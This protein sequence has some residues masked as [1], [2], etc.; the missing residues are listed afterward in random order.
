VLG[1][2]LIFTILVIWFWRRRLLSITVVGAYTAMFLLM[3]YVG[4]VLSYLSLNPLLIGFS[5]SPADGW[6]AI[7]ILHVGIF[8]L[9]LGVFYVDHFLCSG[10]LPGLDELFSSS[11]LRVGM[12]VD[13]LLL[14]V[15]PVSAAFLVLFLPLFPRFIS[16]ALHG[17]VAN[18]MAYR[19]EATHLG[20]HSYALTML[21]YNVLP[22]LSLCLLVS[23]WWTGSLRLV[24]R[25]AVAMA[26]L[27]MLYGLQKQPLVLYALLLTV[28]AYWRRSSRTGAKN[29]A[30]ERYTKRRFLHVRT[31]VSLV[32]LSC[33]LLALYYWTEGV[34]YHGRFGQKIGLTIAVAAAR[35]LFRTST[36]YIYIAR[37]VPSQIPFLGFSNITTIAELLG[38]K[39]RN[40]DLEVSS[41]VHGVTKGYIS[42]DS[43][44]TYYA[45]FG[46][47]GL[48]IMA[49][50][51][52]FGL[53]ALDRYIVSRSR[54]LGLLV[55]ALFMM[56][57]AMYLNETHVYGAI[58]GFG[59]LTS[60]LLYVLLRRPRLQLHPVPSI[61]FGARLV[62]GT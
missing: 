49:F 34:G 9:W 36:G 55:F 35:V 38:I 43:M 33:L 37:L 28:A 61:E 12:S 32:L 42:T 15:V 47:L 3:N 24:A 7:G 30:G 58:L 26:S 5:Y 27:G 56:R 22:Y 11:R 41:I 46:W 16:T 40:L 39:V 1:L 54:D 48:A 31:L 10:Q 59:G 2:P 21:G 29:S 18:K 25:L 44:C 23:S 8:S 4:V 14:L 57:A 62:S 13:R 50:L 52:G 6:R 51:Q 45:Q 19:L 20:L 53:A 17:S 60:A